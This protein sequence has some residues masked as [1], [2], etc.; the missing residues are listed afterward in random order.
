MTNQNQA[1][2]NH[3]DAQRYLT[4]LTAAEREVVELRQRAEKAE[5]RLEAAR[6][7]I[8]ELDGSCSTERVAE[9]TRRCILAWNKRA[10]EAEDHVK[11]LEKAI[12][13]FAQNADVHSGPALTMLS[14]IEQ[15]FNS[16]HERAEKAEEDAKRFGDALAAC[17]LAMGDGLPGNTLES[18]IKHLRSRVEQLKSDLAIKE[19]AMA[20]M[21]KFSADIY[22]VTCL[23][24]T[25]AERKGFSCPVCLRAK[26]EQ[27]EK[28]RKRAEALLQAGRHVFNDGNPNGK[29]LID[30]LNLW[31]DQART[32]AET[33]ERERDEAIHT[34]QQNVCDLSGELADVKREVE[35]LRNGLGSLLDKL[36]VIH[37]DSTYQSVWT[38]YELHNG[39]YSG[40]NYAEEYKKARALV[41]RKEGQ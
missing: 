31:L 3:A 29:T 28:E 17:R 7:V 37:N 30:F 40:P 20:V 33:A 5:E 13:G 15:R 36:E 24:H 39:Q 19:Q 9:E 41:E 16:L 21:Q 34:G 6:M 8:V 14:G 23:Q 22:H 25:D 18:D 26:V 32:R 11:E 10:A 27:L 12:A 35:E 38:L 4:A 2:K 1:Q